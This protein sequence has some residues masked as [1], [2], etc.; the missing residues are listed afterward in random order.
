[1]VSRNQKFEILVGKGKITVKQ[2]QRQ[3]SFGLNY[4]EG[5]EVYA[6]RSQEILCSNYISHIVCSSM[7]TFSINFSYS[8]FYQQS[9]N[10]DLVDK[11]FNPHLKWLM[12]FI[13]CV[14]YR[15]FHFIIL[16][17]VTIFG[18]K[19]YIAKQT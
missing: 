19:Q 8:V 13:W 6:L 7:A 4:Q 10:L 17:I 2:F 16:R 9:V 11:F 5:Q 1:M 18:Y 14:C 3:A 12:F 15:Y